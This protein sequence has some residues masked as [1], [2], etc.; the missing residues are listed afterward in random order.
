[1]TENYDFIKLVIVLLVLLSSIITAIYLF[2]IVEYLIYKIIWGKR[3][4]KP[5]VDETTKTGIPV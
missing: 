5:Y 1:M 3:K 2:L 4:V